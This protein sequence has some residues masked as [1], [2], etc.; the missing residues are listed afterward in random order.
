[1][2]VVLHGPSSPKQQK[3]EQTDSD[4]PWITGINYKKA[5]N[6]T[7]WLLGFGR[8]T[9]C[10]RELKRGLEKDR[11]G[12]KFSH[13]KQRQISMHSA[14]PP[15]EAAAALCE[16]W[17]GY[18]MHLANAREKHGGGRARIRGTACAPPLMSLSI[19]CKKYHHH[20]SH[21]QLQNLAT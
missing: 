9:V 16:L 15:P 2:H 18:C 3:K 8:E 11:I 1:M 12:R 10:L 4:P 20:Q 5:L 6:G 19:P 21:S 13:I 7:L 14:D 17:A